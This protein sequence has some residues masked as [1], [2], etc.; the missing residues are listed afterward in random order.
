MYKKVVC[1]LVFSLLMAVVSR[2]AGQDD[3]S[4]VIATV[5]SQVAPD[6][7]QAVFDVRV[8]EADNGALHAIGVVSDA[9]AKDAIAAALSGT[10][11]LSGVVVLPQ[12]RWGHVRIPVACMRTKPG[13]AAEMAT[14]AV[15]GT[16]LRILGVVDEDWWVQ[17]PDGYIGYMPSSSMV[18]KSAEEMA[19]W[20]KA[21]RLVVTAW[22]QVDVYS[23]QKPSGP[24]DIVT[25][26]VNGSIVE[27]SIAGKSKMIEVTLPDGR[28]G[29]IDRSFVTDISQWASQEFNPDTILNMAYSL[30]GTPYLWGGTSAKA[31]DC[32]GLAKVSY[33]ANGIILMRDA[34]QQAKTGEIM[35]AERWRELEAGDLLFF[36]NADT[37]RVTHVAIYDRDGNYIHSSG[38]VKVNSIDPASEGY[39][40]TPH[41]SSSRIKTRIGSVGITRVAN[42]PWFF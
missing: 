33:F 29:W 16:P 32:S 1:I 23:T 40:T 6:S 42:H 15:M 14:Q 37:G 17:T 9:S 4:K 31:L 25:D 5:K 38:R 10:V 39:L 18:E 21:N 34:S 28:K 12:N 2:A 26:L 7:R 24:R 22:D 30:H 41:L 8:V 19:Q 36:G 11:D 3:A 35:A 13:H 20:R 27:G